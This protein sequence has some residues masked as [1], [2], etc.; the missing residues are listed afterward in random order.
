MVCGDCGHSNLVCTLGGQAL[1]LQIRDVVLY[2]RSG[3][4]RRLS[5]KAG[6]NII[7]GRSGTGKSAI[8]DIVDYCLGR[9][10]FTVPEGVIRDTVE[11]YAVRFSTGDTEVFVAKPSPK[12]GAES[13]STAHFQTGTS[14][15]I[16]TLKELSADS[17]DTAVI[18]SISGLLGIA[19]AEAQ[20]PDESTRDVYRL[21]VR[22]T[23]HYLYQPQSIIASR[24]VLFFQQQEDWATQTLKDTL[25]YFLGAV[26]EERLNLLR[27]LR[28]ARRELNRRK[29]D[30]E[31]FEQMETRGL[32]RGRA[33]LGEAMQA[34][35][36]EEGPANLEDDEVLP[37]LRE[38]LSWE[39]RSAIQVTEPEIPRLQEM[40][41]A[42]SRQLGAV[43]ERL[44]AARVFA[45][46][47]SGYSNEVREQT[48]RLE[49]LELVAPESNELDCPVCGSVVSESVP[50]LSAMRASL[51][52]LSR[53]LARVERERPEIRTHIGQLESE[54]ETIKG[55]IQEL[56][57]RIQSLL[58]EAESARQLQD[59]NAR[60]ARVLGR[61]SLYLD[62][63][64]A[65]PGISDPR[66][67]FEVAQQRVQALAADLE[68]WNVD[69]IQDSHL[70][71]IGKDMTEIAAS[72]PFEH[73]D[74][75]LR[76][77]ARRMSVVA[78][79]PGRPFPMNRMG[80]GQNFLICHVAC[81]LSLHAHFRRED[82]P[83][84]GFLILDQPTQV[85]F[86]SR[87]EYDSLTGSVE[88]TN[89]AKADLAS[90][91]RLFEALFRALDEIL[92]DFQIIVLEHANL[93]MARFQEALVE[94]PWKERGLVPN[95][96]VSE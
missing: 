64:S 2:N 74:W 85:Y 63:V 72:L 42:L 70:N 53:E 50:T 16:P 52:T 11:W 57:L 45:D 37:L 91:R 61:V 5:F 93:E 17:N 54:Q 43:G 20:L 31:E 75:P 4:I 46:T 86:P 49:P 89:R 10:T 81:L 73:R 82:R 27:Q 76:L 83:V 36:L 23:A 25:P 95:S 88:D 30:L 67:E 18:A 90:A 34:G 71:R 55:R 12:P 32:T 58:R 26:T 62:T 48:R 7:T 47:S 44:T 6:A 24:D 8:I 3:E 19:D 94:E 80:S 28:R 33:L 59:Q 78:D 51:E 35:V 69:E 66:E 15:D 68:S 65:G 84:P 96:W 22:H 56:D 1:S 41:G 21:H 79:R 87:E 92:P 38:V 14:I 39:P 60:A 29:R 40:R 77:D 13:Q 9:S